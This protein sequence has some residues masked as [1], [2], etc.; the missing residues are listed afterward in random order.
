MSQQKNAFRTDLVLAA[1]VVTALCSIALFLSTYVVER[2]VAP[3]ARGEE[4]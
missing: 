1:V 2:L 3:W 4:P